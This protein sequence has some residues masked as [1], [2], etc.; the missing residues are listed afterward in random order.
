MQHHKYTYIYLLLFGW[1]LALMY[2][3]CA[4][5]KKVPTTGIKLIKSDK[6]LDWSATFCLQAHSYYDAT[7]DAV[8]FANGR[9][10]YGA[11]WNSWHIYKNSARGYLYMYG[12]FKGIKIGKNINNGKLYSAIWREFKRSVIGDAPLAFVLWQSRYKYVRY[13]RLPDYSW[14]HNE[15]RYVVPI[16]KDNYLPINHPIVHGLIDLTLLTTGISYL[17]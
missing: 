16:G 4:T 12:V 17:K 6:F 15:H 3:G 14:N 8:N 10:T 2:S 1:M 13:Q 5:I 9:R 11:D 7:A